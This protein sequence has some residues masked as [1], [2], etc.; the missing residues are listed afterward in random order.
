MRVAT[1]PEFVKSKKYGI[2][3]H[4]SDATLILKTKTTHAGGVV[5]MVVWS[6]PK[7]VPPSSHKF[8]YRLVFV[9]DGQR[10]VGYDNE[11]GKSDH[12]HLGDTQMAYR[13]RDINTL[14]A[15]FIA[16]VEKYSS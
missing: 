6:L 9:R 10:I 16:D 2:M 3:R 12:K 7:S 8:K 5:E 13:F 11:R 1:S 14:I 15:D 4:M